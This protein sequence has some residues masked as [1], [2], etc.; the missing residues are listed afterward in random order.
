MFGSTQLFPLLWTETRVG[1]AKASIDMKEKEMFC[2]GLALGL[3]SCFLASPGWLAK[4]QAWLGFD[5]VRSCP[6]TPLGWQSIVLRA[7]SF[8]AERGS[9]VIFLIY[10]KSICLLQ[11]THA[12]MGYR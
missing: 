3:T 9:F 5:S 1:K 12:T 6:G 2:I 7:G 11:Q 10:S 4:N 8:A